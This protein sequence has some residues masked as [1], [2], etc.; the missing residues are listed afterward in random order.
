VNVVEQILRRRSRKPGIFS[1]RSIDEGASVP[2]RTITSG[3]GRRTRPLRLALAVLAAALVTAAPA[4]ASAHRATPR[5]VGGASAVITDYPYQV[6]LYDPIA[7]DGGVASPYEGQYCGGSILDATHVVTAGHCVIDPG[8]T[9]DHDVP[10]P[11]STIHVLAG[12]TSL[13]ADGQAEPATERNVAVTAAT[14][15]PGF[16][17]QALDGDVAVLTLAAPL[18]SGTPTIGHATAIAPITPITAA[19]AATDANPDLGSPVTIT[20]WGDTNVEPASP[21][22]HPSY[23]QGLRVAFT[24]LVPQ[25]T[26]AAAYAGSETI[27]NRMVC[28]GEE[29]AGGVDACFGDSGGPLTVAIGDVPTLAGIVSNGVGCALP[30]LP[31]VYTRVG[32]ASVGDFIR[33][34]VAGSAG[35]PGTAPPAGGTPGGGTGSPSGGGTEATPGAATGTQS[36]VP[37]SPTSTPR[38]PSTP[39]TVADHVRPSMQIVA[40][41]CTATRCV[42]NAAVGDAPPSSGIARVTATLRWTARVACRRTG[43][44]TTCAKPAKRA[45]KAGLIGADHWGVTAT[46]LVAGR[47]YTLTLRA[48]DKAGNQQRVARVVVLK[49]TRAHRR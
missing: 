5:I 4:S 47:R 27:T 2:G 29:P 11:I 28:A 32:E 17:L 48:T 35:G 20:G 44:R 22:P 21:S 14:A 1:R 36:P 49:P 31:G 9:P 34:T 6:A 39:A 18:Y 16:T 7:S 46:K 26:C 43:R 40:H 3:T 37:S 12:I 8:P 24:H 30:G 15:F 13:A 10:R 41:D 33:T 25:A 45:L 38:A 23:P 19:Q 42:I